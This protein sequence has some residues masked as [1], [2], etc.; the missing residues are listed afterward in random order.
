LNAA[1]LREIVDKLVDANKRLRIQKLL[2]AVLSSVT[3]LASSPSDSN[4]QQ[5]YVASLDALRTALTTL[6]GEFQPA[7]I[8]RI[9]ELDGGADYLADIVGEIA[10]W[11]AENPATPSVVQA[12]IQELIDRRTAFVTAIEGAATSLQSLG[13][14]IYELEPGQSEIGFL[15]PRNLFNNEFDGLIKELGAVRRIIRAFSEAATGSVEPIEVKQIST[16]DPLFTFAL[17]A[18]TIMMIGKAITWALDS[19]KKVEEIRNLRA[20]TAR[21]NVPAAAKIEATFEEAIKETIRS[22]ISSKL[23]DLVGALKG[24]DGRKNEQRNDLEWALESILARVERGMIVEIRMLPAP[25]VESDDP[26]LQV[27]PPETRAMRE[28][29]AS[30]V[31]PPVQGEPI[32]AIPGV[33]AKKGSMDQE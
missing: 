28:V 6:R 14:E 16:T 20:Q 19:W 11:M 25:T 24:D 2:A 13:I 23:D 31:F 33:R 10:G 18:A 32:L 4:Y 1:R 12:K 26:E 7:E 3:N 27:E 21:L 8:A 15:L 5:Q 30:L 17:N 29:A 9:E 22:E